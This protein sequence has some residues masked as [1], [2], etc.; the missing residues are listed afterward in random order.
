[1]YNAI[2]ENKGTDQF[3]ATTKDYKFVMGQGGANAIDALL[4]SLCGCVA[5][6]V[7]ACLVGRKIAYS[8]FTIEAEG[9]RSDDRLF[10]TVI[11]IV[12]KVEGCAL[13]QADRQE[14]QQQPDHCP[15]Y[16]TLGKALAIS[17][18]VA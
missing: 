14:L 12:L 8:A 3:F 10:L 9:A 16:N 17:F 4:A 5:H 7:R 18:S 13:T 6:H 1:M 2:V 15:I 11:S